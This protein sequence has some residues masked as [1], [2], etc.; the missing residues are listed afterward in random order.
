M[1]RALPL[2]SI[3]CSG[4]ALYHRSYQGSAL[5]AMVACLT[6]PPGDPHSTRGRSR[7]LR[8]RARSLSA[9]PR[10]QPPRPTPPLQSFDLT[11]VDRIAPVAIDL[12]PAPPATPEPH[13]VQWS[14]L[15]HRAS[16]LLDSFLARWREAP[17]GAE[18]VDGILELRMECALPF[19]WRPFFGSSPL[20]IEL[21]D[22]AGAAQRSANGRR[23]V[24]TEDRAVAWQICR[25]RGS[26][27]T[28]FVVVGRLWQ[29]H[30]PKIQRIDIR[31]P[32]LYESEGISLKT[33]RNFASALKEGGELRLIFKEGALAAKWGAKS[34][35]FCPVERVGEEFHLVHRARRER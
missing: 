16:S 18:V 33:L 21:G 11:P 26:L 5:L 4:W 7:S 34:P 13:L 29:F 19:D 22:V 8:G 32:S 35:L 25:E 14:A 12:N 15:P 1:R 20:F 10:V 31:S 2:I 24:V 30:R 17:H 23:I 9:P 3:L 28:P 27:T 6:F